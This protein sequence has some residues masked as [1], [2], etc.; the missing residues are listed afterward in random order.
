METQ[1][2]GVKSSDLAYPITRDDKPV[3]IYCCYSLVILK[4][5]FHKLFLYCNQVVLFA[6]EATN[7]KYPGMVHGAIGSGWREADRLIEL[8]ADKKTNGETSQSG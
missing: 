2:S 6:G 1:K 4:L 5:E 7:P 8:Y 3:S